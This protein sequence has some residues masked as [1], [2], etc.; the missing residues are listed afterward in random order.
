ME[1]KV[2]IFMC[3]HKPFDYLPPCSVAVAGGAKS[4]PVPDGAIPDYGEGGSIS[5]KNDEYC[6]LTVQYYAW[7]NEDEDYYGFCHY[8]R[9]FSFFEGT[10]KPYLVFRRLTEKAKRKLIP[11]KSDILTKLDGYDII[12]P[13]GEDVGMSVYDKY[14]SSPDMFKEDVDLF[15]SLVKEKFPHLTNYTDEYMK[16][17]KQCFCNMFIMKRELFFEYSEA[18]FSLLSD[19]D[20]KKTL[21]G[22]FQKDRT[23][24]Y[25]AERF[26]G[27]Y[28]LYLKDRGARIYECLRVDTDVPFLKRLIFKFLPPETK[29]RFFFK[30]IFSRRA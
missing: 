9:F 16:G 13:K 2:K 6:E 30:R 12:I 5:E 24:G 1:K 17:R 7:K 21:H 20:A 27:I 8:R 14:V 19:F 23:D 15:I 4:K 22:D 28:L 11:E 26:L 25:L 18:L 3:A 10:K 29:I